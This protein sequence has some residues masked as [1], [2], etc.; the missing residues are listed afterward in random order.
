MQRFWVLLVVAACAGQGGCT[1][2]RLP[3]A[4]ALEHE[5]VR[6]GSE[7]ELWPG[8]DP[9]VVPLAVLEG[10]NT[11]LFRH[12]DPPDGFAAIGEGYVFSG[13]HPLVVS[14]TSAVIGGVR[15]AAIVMDVSGQGRSIT[16]MA[17]LALHEAFHVFQASTGRRWGADE[18][19]MFVYPV[20]DA[21]LL[22]LRRLETEALRRAVSAGVEDS[23]AGWAFAAMD[24]RSERYSELDP[25]F[26]AY[27][28]GIEA[29]EGTAAYVECK[30]SGEMPVE[31]PAGG[32]DPEAVRL[33]GYAT[34]AA[35]ALLLDAFEPGWKADFAL[36]DSLCLDGC[37]E[38]ALERSGHARTCAFTES[39][40]AAITDRARSDAESLIQTWNS[41]R[42]DF[43][44]APGWRVVLEAAEEHPLWPQGF[45]PM[46]VRRV[47]G[48][49]LHT[50]FINLGNELGNLNVLEGTA[51]TE[52][53]GPHPLFNGVRR[54]VLS[55]LE[56]E[57]EVVVQEGRMTLKAPGVTADFLGAS[58]VRT[59]N[60]LLIRIGST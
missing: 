21:D 54:V 10:G 12:P 41:R 9:M 27:E 19:Y 44:S 46:N 2:D 33:R 53:V 52:G 50:R 49:L 35:F 39:E 17:A 30:A 55:G 5:V 38:K 20:E 4:I 23:V 22:A 58:V 24:A 57:P 6:I 36:Y 43:V 26:Q 31:L 1:K 18:T 29:M 60:T 3:P 8:Y 13:S 37:L 16:D 32:F 56:S 48:G 51:L 34:G 40:T 11:Y 14:N 47:E 28:R 45:D 42:E 25:A 59:A 15:T 7:Q